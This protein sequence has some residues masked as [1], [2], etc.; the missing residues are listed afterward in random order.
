[1]ENGTLGLQRLMENCRR[2][3]KTARRSGVSE[4]KGHFISGC[5]G[6]ENGQRFGGTAL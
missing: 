3:A 4:G 5:P 1:M 6:G 2:Q